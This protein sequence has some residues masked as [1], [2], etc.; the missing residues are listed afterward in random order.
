MIKNPK[1]LRKL[2][3]DLSRKRKGSNNR[4]KSRVKIVKSQRMF[5]KYSIY[6]TRIMVYIVMF[7][8]IM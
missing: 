2:Q 1:H 3:R 7:R 8:R 5:F 6:N 4:Y